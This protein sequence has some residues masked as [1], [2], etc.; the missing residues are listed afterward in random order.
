[1]PDIHHLAEF[2]EGVAIS[3]VIMRPGKADYGKVLHRQGDLLAVRWPSGKDSHRGDVTYIPAKT[4]IFKVIG[5][6][7]SVNEHGSPVGYNGKRATKF[8]IC[9]KV[10]EFEKENEGKTMHR[11]GDPVVDWRGDPA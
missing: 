2:E 6:Y 9:E 8:L 11:T 7:F 3:G 1:M 4:V 5:R 10:M